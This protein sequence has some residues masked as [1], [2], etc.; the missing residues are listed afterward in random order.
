[1]DHDPTESR[2]FNASLA[3]GIEV[4]AA[5]GPENPSMGLT[6]LALA[7]GITKS[8]AQRYVFTFE[9]LGLLRKD[10]ATKKYSL[11]PRTLGLGYRYLLANKLLDR[12]NPYLLD[13]CRKTNENVNLTEADEVDMV[14]IGRFETHEY[15][16]GHMP[17]GS[18]LPIFCTASGRA[19]LSALPDDDVRRILE[20][21]DR[22]NY[23]PNTVTDLDALM[24]MIVQAR[25]D[26]F[27][28][29]EGEYFRDDINLAAPVLDHQ[30]APV[31]AV[32][33]SAATA[34]WDMSRMKKELA[35]LLLETARLI[36]TPAPGR[37]GAEAF[38]TGFKSSSTLGSRRRQ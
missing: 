24:D 37:N 26:G 10:P 20:R 34:R 31:G 33:I 9:T 1:M 29:A 13:L 22:T 21:S 3:T 7:A 25:Q 18:R 30:G 8:A 38:R 23:T 4:L 5:F 35:P 17:I 15:M 28:C 12:A 16:P 11:T 19:Y 14:Y 2:L 36:S 6:D 32:N 27:S